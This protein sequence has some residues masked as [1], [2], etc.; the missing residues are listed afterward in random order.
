[1]LVAIIAVVAVVLLIGLG[2]RRTRRTERRPGEI[3]DP[4]QG[5][6]MGMTPSGD[7]E[8]PPMDYIGA[9]PD[10]LV[11]N[12]EAQAGAWERERERYRQR[13]ESS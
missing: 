5:P 8:H 11:E 2:V 1:M 6:V 7:R 4:V 12:P 13:E 10:D 9:E 3:D